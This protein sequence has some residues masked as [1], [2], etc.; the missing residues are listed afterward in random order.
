MS[1]CFYFAKKN[2]VT[3]CIKSKHN[4]IQ[5]Q[6]KAFYPVFSLQLYKT[7][8][9]YNCFQKGL[10]HADI[11][12]SGVLAVLTDVDPSV[13]G[14]RLNHRKHRKQITFHFEFL[15]LK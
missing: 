8:I 1:V 12:P 15:L 3:S 2:H 7:L 9:L 11:H 13:P 14:F 10:T 6:N 4:R 5:E